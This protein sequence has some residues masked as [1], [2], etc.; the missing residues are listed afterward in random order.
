[1]PEEVSR[2]GFMAGGWMMVEGFGLRGFMVRREARRVRSKMG[3]FV[4]KSMAV[5]RDLLW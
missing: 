4:R 2:V 5:V 1:M 3:L